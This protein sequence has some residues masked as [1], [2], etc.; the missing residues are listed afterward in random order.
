[1]VNTELELTDAGAAALRAASPEI[2]RFNAELRALLGDSGFGTTA[3]VMR[4]LA[5]WES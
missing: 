1:M 3:V 5:H 4:R 2:D